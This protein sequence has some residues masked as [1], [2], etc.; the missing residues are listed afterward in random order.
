MEEERK[1]VQEDIDK[2]KRVSPVL[3]VK[4]Y[5][6]D[7]DQ[8]D[9]HVAVALDGE[10]EKETKKQEDY[11]VLDEST[12][13]DPEQV[14]DMV[15]EK[16][17]KITKIIIQV[18]VSPPAI[19]MEV[20]EEEKDE[21]E[22]DDDDDDDY[23]DEEEGEEI[24]KKRE[25]KEE[26]GDEV[27]EKYKINREEEEEKTEG[28]YWVVELDD[29][30][31]VYHGFDLV[32][33]PPPGYCWASPIDINDSSQLG[34]VN[35]MARFAVEYYNKKYKRK[36]QFVRVH[37][38]NITRACRDAYYITLLAK[39]LIKEDDDEEKAYHTK[40]DCSRR[41]RISISANIIEIANPILYTPYGPSSTKSSLPSSTTK[42]EKNNDEE[43]HLS[44]LFTSTVL[45]IN[46][47]MSETITTRK[48][49]NA[50]NVLQLLELWVPFASAL[51]RVRELKPQFDN[52]K[53]QRRESNKYK[54]ECINSF[55][56]Y[57]LEG[58]GSDLTASIDLTSGLGRLFLNS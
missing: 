2:E 3:E 43:N 18:S 21:V 10:E 56:L 7:H 28:K 4:V 35:R 31:D 46:I 45:D 50:R 24:K 12:V 52:I 14:M 11:S 29:G 39:D 27:E 49:K 23:E 48:I 51:K 8:L 58:I 47:L 9:Q 37:H 38:A 33:P 25:E 26:E 22:E 44:H 20:E 1:G 32:R 19:V 54:K 13:K 42:R 5:L 55:L 16:K 40:V 57:R 30:W 41:G 36:V 17:E 15:V 53:R 34:V 6:G